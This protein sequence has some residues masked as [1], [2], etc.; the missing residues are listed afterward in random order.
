LIWKVGRSVP[1]RSER[2]APL[3]GIVFVVILVAAIF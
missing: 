3:S 1:E 2:L